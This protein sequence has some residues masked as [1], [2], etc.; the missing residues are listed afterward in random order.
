MIV[1]LAEKFS[2]FLG[3]RYRTDGPWSGQE[4][5]EDYLVPWL[6]D[7][8]SNKNRLVVV[9]DGVAGVPSSFLEE[10]F[11]GLFRNTDWSVSDIQSALKLSAEDPDLWPYLS[12]ATRFMDEAARRR[13]RAN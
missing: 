2:P 7:A 3:G 9:L 10:A 12:L 1:R 8:V 5:R 6:R 11:G 4:F 13:E